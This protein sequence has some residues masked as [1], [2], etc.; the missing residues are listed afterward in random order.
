MDPVITS[1]LEKKGVK[2]ARVSR[3]EIPYP[4]VGYHVCESQGTASLWANFLD[5]KLEDVRDTKGAVQQS[6]SR[7]KCMLLDPEKLAVSD[8]SIQPTQINIC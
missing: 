6:G 5:G 4:N 3:L 2:V 8:H 7:A 1:A